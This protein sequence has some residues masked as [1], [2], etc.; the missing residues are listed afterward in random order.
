M[1][2]IS[3]I[4]L[5]LAFIFSFTFIVAF[6][7]ATAVVAKESKGDSE[8]S[9]AG[10]VIAAFDASKLSD[11]S[12]YDPTNYVNPTGDTI[13]IAVVSSFSGPGAVNGELHFLPISW[14]AYDIN[15]RGGILVDGK[16][17]LIEVIKADH[18]SKADQCKKICERLILQDKVHVLMGTNGSHLMKIINEVANKYKAIAWNFTAPAD[19]IQDATNFGRYSFAGGY[20]TGQMGRAVAYYYGQ[21][22]KKEKKF[23]ILCQ[24][25]VLGHAL[26]DS[27]KAGLKEYYPN[28]QLVGEDYHKLFLTDFAPYLEKVKASG[29][30][31]IYTGNWPPDSTNL[32]KQAR[33]MKIN[34][35]LAGWALAADITGLQDIG[36]EGTKGLVKVDE[37]DMPAPFKN[38]DYVKFY[39]EWHKQWKNWPAPYNSATYEHPS[40]VV[41]G[42]FP[43]QTYWLLSAIER[44]KS[45]D[46]EKI[47]MVLENDTYRMVNGHVMKMRACDHKAIQ[48]LSVSEA[49]PP[50]EQK[51]SMTIPPYYWFK[52]VSWAGKGHIIPAAKVLPWMDQKLDRCKG[53]NDWGE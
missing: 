47:L 4:L 32:I 3:K 2:S 44:A 34:I 39:K 23:Y 48:N 25:Y 29:A 42:H 53:K 50:A 9:W 30:E 5:K 40:G 18:M 24:D 31:V 13:K 51:A 33:Q 21:V 7:P 6:N 28:A 45:T 16:K 35:P 17:K 46:P 12:G 27:F 14:A 38:P 20:S 36:I 8:H 43:M 37:Y 49:V 52:N 1:K 15:K 41:G 22:K 10:K 11:M 19:D 26:A